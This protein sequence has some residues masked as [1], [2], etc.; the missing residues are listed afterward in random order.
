MTSGQDSP[1]ISVV[2][3]AYTEQRWPNLVAAVE[4]VRRQSLAPREI[5]LVVDY[6]SAL[7]ARAEREL[8]VRVIP[9]KE[10]RGLSGARNG[11]IAATGGDLVAFLDDD[12]VAR[13]DWLA[14]LSEWHADPRVMGAGGR[15]EP[16]W[17]AGRPR[18]F[19][20]EFD[21]VVGCSYRGLPSTTAPIR[22]P[23][24]GSMCIR[25][26]VFAA[27]GGFVSGIGRVGARP[28]GCEETELSIRAR[29]RWPERTFLYEPRAIAHHTVPSERSRWSYFHSRCFAEG[30]SKAYVSRL[31]G[32]QDGLASERLHAFHTLP[33]GVGRGLA[34][35]ARHGD[36]WGL[37]RAGAIM[38]GLA[39]TVA[40]YLAGRW[41]R[42]TAN[43]DAGGPFR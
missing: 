38:A 7:Q 31:V 19:P 9:N 17:I 10:A 11:G 4:S 14:Y 5:V 29:H 3:C 22:N 41:S 20:P 33:L 40:G 28:F 13:P 15:L 36:V 30:Q 37:T 42:R 26:E 23:L 25:R 32:A 34:D 21:W 1:D 2:I 8:A 18:W 43:P 39:W 12:A 27:V 35:L 16:N 24:G 6:N